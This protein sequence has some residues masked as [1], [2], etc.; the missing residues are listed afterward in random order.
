MSVGN[1]STGVRPGGSSS[2]LAADVGTCSSEGLERP[3]AIPP[4]RAPHTDASHNIC[5][6]FTFIGGAAPDIAL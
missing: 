1:S 6:A 4:T 5:H 2:V 3:I